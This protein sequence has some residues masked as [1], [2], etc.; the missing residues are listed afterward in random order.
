[1]W[2]IERVR[3]NGK[4]DALIYNGGVS[5][6]NDILNLYEKWL[7]LLRLNRVESGTVVA[8]VG[9]FSPATC[10]A[11]L[12]LIKNANIIVPLMPITYRKHEEFLDIAEVQFVLKPN[13]TQEIL[14]RKATVT[15][16]LTRFLITKNDA[17]LIFFSSGS[18]GKS[19]AALHAMVPFLDKFRN[20]RPAMRTLIFLLFDHIGGINTF[21]YIFANG[22]VLVSPSDRSPSAVCQTIEKSNVELL[23]VSPTFLN[24]LLLSEEHYRYD[25]SS[26]K[27]ITYGT[28]PMPAIT[29][30]RL[31]QALPEVTLQQTYGL[32]EV[33]ILHSKSKSNNSLW[34]KVGG[35]EFET[36]VV[37]GTLWIKAETAMIGYLNA[38]SPFDKAGWLNTEDSVEVDGEYLRFLGRESEIIN[39]GGEKVYPAEVEGH[40]LKLAN[41]R[42]AIVFGEPTPI[43]G[44][45]VVVSVNLIKPETVLELKKRIRRSLKNKLDSFK[46]PQ[47]VIVVERN[48]FNERYKRMRL[49]RPDGVQA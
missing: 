38:P 9:D 27:K 44:Q 23:P 46:I 2:L 17:G 45:M 21:L 42:D 10:A 36:K 47:K 30:K 29:L 24:L 13:L 39:V 25:L 11:F 14:P 6:Y 20:P 22:G 34:V 48:Q 41:I 15:N 4:R 16:K 3:K 35:K 8:I 49:R 1:M 19:K 5:R 18:T 43:T 26:L 33:G 37:D 32:S 12:A 40:V 7:E 31:T 28:E